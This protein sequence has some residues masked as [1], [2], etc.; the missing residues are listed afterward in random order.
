MGDSTLLTCPRRVDG[1]QLIRSEEFLWVQRQEMWKDVSRPKQRMVMISVVCVEWGDLLYHHRCPNSRPG[2]CRSHEFIYERY[3]W[4]ATCSY[5][6]AFCQEFLEQT[7]TA[8]HASK[9]R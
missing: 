8:C 5:S 2:R 3:K 9:F 1:R 7:P 4:T 6:K